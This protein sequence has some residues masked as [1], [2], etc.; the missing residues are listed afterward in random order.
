MAKAVRTHGG[1]AI[2]ND[3]ILRGYVYALGGYFHGAIEQADGFNKMNEDGSVNFAG[4]K[5]VGVLM[6]NR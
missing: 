2:L 1:R 6:V 5:Y 4:G 3:V